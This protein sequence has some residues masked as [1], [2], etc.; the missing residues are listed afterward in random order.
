MLMELHR[1]QWRI[2][3]S[4]WTYGC[5]CWETYDTEYAPLDRITDCECGRGYECEY[6]YEYEY[7]CGC[8]VSAKKRGENFREELLVNKQL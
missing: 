6:E 2:H 7:E 1:H 8:D 4:T 3:F 5:F